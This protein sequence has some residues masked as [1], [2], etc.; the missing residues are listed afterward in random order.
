MKKPS[1]SSLPKA[2]NGPVGMKEITDKAIYDLIKARAAYAPNAIA[3]AAPERGPL[4]YAHLLE[5]VDYVAKTL[6]AMEIGRND[7]VAMV[8]P[9]GPEMASAFLAISSIATCA[10]LNPGGRANEFD[11]LFS[12]LRAKALIVQSGTDS[13]AIAVAQKHSIR[14]IEL[15]PAVGS[16]A[17]IFLLNGEK[18]GPAS[19]GGF[20]RS[21]EVA[22]ILYTSG[23]TAR[24]KMVP[25][26]HS[27]LLAS[28]GNIAATLQLSEKDRCLNV[29]PLFHIHG[30]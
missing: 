16:Q 28:A 23:T 18:Y 6:K 10:P 13:Q 15:L 5:Q 4:T 29:M 14:V 1:S 11:F 3:I 7:R 8:L 12:D 9:N 24:P 19:D 20:A 21:D 30:L 22:L 25:L 26:T 17:G 27:N 2:L